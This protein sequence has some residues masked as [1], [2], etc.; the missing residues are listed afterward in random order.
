MNNPT[1]EKTEERKKRNRG[2]GKPKF[3]PTDEERK[4]VESLSGFGVPQDQISA[5]IRDGIHKETLEIA[6]RKEIDQGKAKINAQ[7][8]KRLFQKCADGDTTALIW[9][10]KTQM[11]WKETKIIEDVAEMTRV[12]KLESLVVDKDQLKAEL[13]KRHLPTNIFKNEDNA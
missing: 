11:R 13:E 1:I 6:F 2:G 12:E 3:I 5:I 10:T 4:M 8:G 7:I 9:W